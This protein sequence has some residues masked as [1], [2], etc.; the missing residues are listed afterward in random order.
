MKCERNTRDTTGRC[1][2]NLMKEDYEQDSEP[3]ELK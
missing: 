3:P 2:F 1:F